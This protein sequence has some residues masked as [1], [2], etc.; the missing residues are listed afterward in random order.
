MGILRWRKMLL[1]KK[2]YPAIIS[3]SLRCIKFKLTRILN[4]L[5]NILRNSG[6]DKELLNIR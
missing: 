6:Y 3:I 4:N 2:I 1:S 5:N